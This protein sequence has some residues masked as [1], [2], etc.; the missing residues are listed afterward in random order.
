MTHFKRLTSS[1]GTNGLRGPEPQTGG[2]WKVLRDEPKQCWF[3]PFFLGFVDN[4][5]NIE[6]H[7]P[8]PFKIHLYQM[9]CNDACIQ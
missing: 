9:Y 7:Q 3:W 2:S 5:N 4:D 1:G 8:Y 6:H